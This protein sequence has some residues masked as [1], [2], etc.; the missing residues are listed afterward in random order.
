VEVNL[1]KV[2]FSSNVEDLISVHNYIKENYQA[3]SLLIKILHGAAVLTA[4]SKLEDIKAVANYA[5]PGYC[6]TCKEIIFTSI[7]GNSQRTFQ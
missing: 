7:R 3:P 1:L 2:I 5:A 6:R 4:V